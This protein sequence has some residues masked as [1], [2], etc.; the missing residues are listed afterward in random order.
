VN[1]IFTR[2]TLWA[3]AGKGSAQSCII[4]PDFTQMCRRRLISNGD[5]RVTGSA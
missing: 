1:A 2:R 5:I 4:T 3:V